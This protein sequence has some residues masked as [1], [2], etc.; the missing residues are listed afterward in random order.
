M[1]SPAMR[2]TGCSG[3]SDGAVAAAVVLYEERGPVAIVSLNRPERLNTLT[4]ETVGG[5]ADAIDA[6]FGD[7]SARP[8]KD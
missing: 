2:W 5:A 1:R 8:R 4:E 7:Y 6:P 3:W